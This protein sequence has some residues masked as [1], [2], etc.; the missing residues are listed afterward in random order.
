MIAVEQL[1]Q[2]LQQCAEGF[3]LGRDVEVAMTMIDL[4]AR[5]QA[6]IDGAPPQ[7]RQ[8]WEA[9]LGLMFEC[10]QGQNWLALADYLQYECV[11]LLGSLSPR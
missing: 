5:L 7:V 1:I 4:V 8:D 11:E 10:Q 2:G 3:R 9:M 6:F